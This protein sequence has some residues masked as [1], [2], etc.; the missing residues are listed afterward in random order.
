MRNWF[1]SFQRDCSIAKRDDESNT[2]EAR[3][4][5][6]SESSGIDIS[7]DISYAVCKKFVRCTM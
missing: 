7:I 2:N 1:I 6:R 3:G 5:H 4:A